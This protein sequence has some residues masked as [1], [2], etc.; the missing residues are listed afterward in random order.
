MKDNILLY[1]V[2]VFIDL[3]RLL[4]YFYPY[5]SINRNDLILLVFAMAIQIAGF[6]LGTVQGI[7]ALVIFLVVSIV[8][9]ERK[10]V[11]E[12]ESS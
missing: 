5:R 11:I 2:I 6:W 7:V 12:L 8:L 3:S 10:E 1:T 4:F 9:P